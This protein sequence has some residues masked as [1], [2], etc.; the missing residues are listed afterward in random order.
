MKKCGRCLKEKELGEFHRRGK[1]HQ[2]RCKMCSRDYHR[3]H[4]ERNKARYK[5]Q[6][7]IQRTKVQVVVNSLKD[8]PCLDCNRKFPPYV[9]DFDHIED[10]KHRNVSNLAHDGAMAKAIAEANKCE[11]VCSNCHRIRTHERRS[12]SSSG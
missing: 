9:M 10:N 4:Y 12:T 6:A 7:Q 5:E 1:G 11:V 3:A 8:V 2:S